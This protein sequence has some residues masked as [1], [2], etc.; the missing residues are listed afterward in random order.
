MVLLY[1]Y[2]LIILNNVTLRKCS[3]VPRNFVRGGRE[4][5]QIHLRTEDRDLGA[6]AP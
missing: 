1:I 2:K 6:V 3:D 4:V 5:Q